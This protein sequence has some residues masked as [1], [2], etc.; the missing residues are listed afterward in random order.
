MKEVRYIYVNNERVSLTKG[1]FGWRV[2]HPIQDDEGKIIWKNLLFGGWG[3]LLRLLFIF[4]V[5]ALAFFGFKEVTN[6]CRDL[7]ENP[8]D[9]TN[10]D[11]SVYHGIP[12]YTTGN[13][14]ARLNPSYNISEVL[15]G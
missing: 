6:S 1:I 11:C 15:D 9:Y 2:I 14:W 3:N 12:R 4:L 5:I 8:C 13:D 10:L 7:A